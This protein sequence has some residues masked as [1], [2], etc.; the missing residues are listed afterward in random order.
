MTQTIRTIMAATILLGTV[1]AAEEPS[2]GGPVK[3]LQT[4]CTALKKGDI[5]AADALTARSAKLP[6]AHITQYNTVFSKQADA[7]FRFNVHTDAFTQKGDCAAVLCDVG[8][9]DTAK[10]MRA[11]LL[12]QDGEWKVCLGFWEQK[13]AWYPLGGQLEKDAAEVEAWSAQKL[14]EK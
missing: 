3:A 5:D 8:P 10:K 14:K 12:R 6:E 7:A 4:Y 13:N 9:E 1:T 2:Q 11:L